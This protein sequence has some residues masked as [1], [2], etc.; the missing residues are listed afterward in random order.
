MFNFIIA[1]FR[2]SVLEHKLIISYLATLVIILG[3][4]L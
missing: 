2:L 4:L 1:P 3:K